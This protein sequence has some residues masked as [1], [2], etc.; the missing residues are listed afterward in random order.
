MSKLKRPLT[1]LERNFI[2]MLQLCEHET[3]VAGECG[4]DT[5][6]DWMK[7]HGRQFDRYP[8]TCKECMGTAFVLKLRSVPLDENGVPIER[9][10][11][12][13]GVDET[14]KSV[15][16]IGTKQPLT[17][18]RVTPSPA[19]SSASLKARAAED[20]PPKPG[21]IIGG[22]AGLIASKGGGKKKRKK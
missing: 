12:S 9:A 22:V 5:C 4:C 7:A 1:A 14:G 21:E 8:G 18:R 6:A 19:V 20:P 13:M 2:K 10:P 3:C 17:R 15:R 11:R 16:V